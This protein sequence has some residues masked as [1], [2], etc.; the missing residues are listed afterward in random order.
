MKKSITRFLKALLP[1]ILLSIVVLTLSM[2]VS[3]SNDD[4]PLPDTDGDGVVDKDDNC[5]ETSNPDQED[6]DGDGIG[7]AC[8][9]T[10]VKQDKTNI[11][12]AL[13]AT[14]ACIMTLENG[15]AIQT[16]LTDFM[17]IS[18]GDTTNQVWV[19][20]LLS[21]LGQVVPSSEEARLD[22]SI[23][24]GTYVYNLDNETWFR[25]DNQNNRVVIRFPTSPS[26]TS[27]DGKIILENYS[28]TQVDFSDNT[29]YLPVSLDAIFTVNNE[30]VVVLD[31]N[32]AKYLASSGLPIPIELDFSVYVNPYSV[33]IVIDKTAHTS[34][35]INLD[36]ADDSEVCS[37]GVHV[38][39]ELDH[40][41]FSALTQ[42]DVLKLTFAVYSNDLTIQSTGGLAEILQIPEPSISQI[43]AFLDL[44]VLY[45]DL[46][47]AD[48]LVDEDSAGEVIIW[49]E[50]K[51]GTK[52]DAANYF[53]D[54]V[55]EVEALLTSYFGSSEG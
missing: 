22:F 5:P 36:F 15:T 48:V 51:N 54:F 53:E 6:T 13:D 18:N 2:L 29:L 24:E 3:C 4:A 25:Q 49:L 55:N 19:D 43:N 38:E 28:D 35:T 34:Y 23:I 1:Y 8:D 50:F 14:L 27:N 40:N 21:G 47:I 11:Q 44:E 20:S 16:F 31:L 45:N 9:E 7:D 12:N 17:G 10:T 30:E 26:K 52:E 33:S 32:N 37:A 42:E 46:K 41:K 39:L